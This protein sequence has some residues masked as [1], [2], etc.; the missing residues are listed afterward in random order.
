MRIGITSDIHTDISPANH[1]IVKHLSDI[2]QDSEIDVFIICGDISPSPLEFSKTISAFQDIQCKKLLVAGNHDIWI[3]SKNGYITSYQKYEI[4]TALCKEHDFHHLG[5]SAMIINEIGFCGTIGWYDYSFRSAKYKIPYE[6]YANKTFG[7]SIWNDVN[8]AKWGKDDPKVAKSFEDDLKNQID[9]I[10]DKVSRIIVTTHHIPFRECV[11]YRNDPTWDFFSAFMGSEGLG[12]ICLNEPLV[13]HAF[14]GHTHTE[15]N[16][17]IKK[18]GNGD[19]SSILAICSPVG[20]LT[21]PPRD[22]EEYAQNRL[23]IVE[24]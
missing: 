1:K 5:D 20:Y 9:S 24:I 16:I 19:L 2:V 22:L 10:K 13:S 6:N 4:I 8:Y 12:K 7:G 15:Y 23:K 14:F 18:Q 11:T 3:A 17:E 21:E